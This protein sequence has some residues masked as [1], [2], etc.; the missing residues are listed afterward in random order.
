MEVDSG[1]IKRDKYSILLPTYNER[2]NL[3]II[4][5]LIIKYLDES[6]VDYEVIIID[7]G[8]PDGTSEV[9]R[10]LQK[11]YGS[12]KIVLRPRE[13]KLGL[14]TAYIHGIQQASG[15]FI[16]IMDADLS[17]HPKFIPEFIKLQLK[18]DYDI[19]S[20]TRYKG[21]GGVYG[22]DFKRKLISRGANFLTQLMLRPG[23]SDLTGSFRLYKK[24]VL[25]KLILSC[26]S[27]GYVF[28]MEM[29][30]RARQF[31]YSIGEVP[32]SFVDRVYGESKLGGSEIVQFAKALLY[33]FATT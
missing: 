13:M 30:I 21:S 7:D 20:G 22:W 18:Y 17:H 15:N 29:I 16:I 27:K 28:Q 33:L 8:S 4:I 31:D 10:Q 14:G 24:E 1:L 26:V 19:V 11:L 5:W 23:V 6:G 12:S 2:E 25:E 3:P 9:A 32:I